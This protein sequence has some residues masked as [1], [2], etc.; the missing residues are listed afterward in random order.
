[1]KSLLPLALVFLCLG[2]VFGQTPQAQQ[3]AFE[4]ADAVWVANLDGSGA[5]KIAGGQAPALSP[6]AT[7]LAFNTVQP[8]GQPAHRKIAVAN[9]ADGKVTVFNDVPSD[10]CLE[11]AWSPDGA[12]LLF[13]LYVKDEMR[14]ALMNA[15]GSGFHYLQKEGGKT[16]AYWSAC[17]ARDGQSIYAQDMEVIHQ[18]SL[19]GADL[20]K[21][22]VAK[23]AP[24]ASMGGDV[25]LAVSPDGGKLLMDLEMDEPVKRKDWDGPASA[26]WTLDFM[27]GKATRVSP[28]GQLAWTGRWISPDQIVFLTQGPKDKDP[29]VCRAGLDGKGKTQILT[30]AR[31][32]SVAPVSDK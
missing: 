14:L 20:K 7:L 19:E 4:R 9:L 23:L 21:W 25:T 32:M 6:D 26:L 15:D 13:T 16:K 24:K 12:K 27:T 3:I 22:V 30:D 5:K 11:P 18:L 2:T 29:V 28:K 1:M 10:N 31:W 8:M 17:W